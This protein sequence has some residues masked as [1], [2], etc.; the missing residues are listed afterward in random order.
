MLSNYGYRYEL[1]NT[2]RLN[3]NTCSFAPIDQLI[4]ADP[5]EEIDPRK[6]HKIE[7]QGSMGSCRG[8]SL[9]SMGEYCYYIAT[10][11]VTQ[12]SPL[13]AYYATQKVDGLA[14][15]D[16]GATISGG[17]EVA[18]GVGFCPLEIM[19]YPNPVRYRWELPEAA[20]KAAGDFK[21]EKW[22][23]IRSYEQAFKFL[24][25]GQ[26]GVDLGLLWSDSMSPSSEGLILDY[27]PGGGGHAVCFL[28]YSKRTDSLGRKFLILV[29]SWDKTWGKGGFAE[30]AP[31]AVEKIMR[32]GWT[33]ARGLSDMVSP[34]FRK[35]PDYGLF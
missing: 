1:E 8:H 20:L 6:W 13:F 16:R 26:G 28:G 33:V 30:V 5:P 7:N 34:K 10:G 24:A 31:S 21:C 12:F 25:S 27:T 4:L 14:G 2:L 32:A 22:Y 3:K 17:M 18:T 15:A 11:E 35:V 19:P 23:E 9:S 29:N